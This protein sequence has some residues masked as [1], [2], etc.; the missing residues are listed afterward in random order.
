MKFE[1]APQKAGSR[2]S[3]HF[4]QI[5]TLKERRAGFQPATGVWPLTS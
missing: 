4:F 3:R 2:R 5:R 1:L